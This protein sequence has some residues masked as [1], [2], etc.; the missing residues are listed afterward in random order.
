[1][2]S[3]RLVPLL[4]L[5]IVAPFLVYA[6]AAI[7][8]AR[9]IARREALTRNLATAQLGARLVGEQN[10]D[11]VDYLRSVARHHGFR[12][13]LVERDRPALRRQLEEARRLNEEF[14]SVAAYAAGGPLLAISPRSAARSRGPA[15]RFAPPPPDATAAGYLRDA[16]HGRVAESGASPG[17]DPRG[18]LVVHLAVPV[19]RPKAVIG[20]LVAAVRLRVI[21]EWLKPINIGLGGVIYVVDSNGMVVATSRSK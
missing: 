6:W 2:R 18:G 3:R 14:A 12:R 7:D 13:A 19:T 5:L 9:D 15:P 1:M 20:V 11:A 16:S 17:G 21:R 10:G 8:A 4:I